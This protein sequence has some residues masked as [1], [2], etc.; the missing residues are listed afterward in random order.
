[1]KISDNQT[2]ILGAPGCGKT[3]SLLTL[4]DKCFQQGIKPHEIAFVSFS[5]RAANEALERACTKF[6][7][8]KVD[9]PYFRTLHSLAFHQLGLRANEV[10][11]PEDYNNLGKLLNAPFTIF[12][13]TDEI[14]NPADFGIEKKGDLMLFMESLARAKMAD[15]RDVYNV[16]HNYR[17]SW[18]EFERFA[19][20]YHEYRQHYSLMDFTDMLTQFVVSNKTVGVKVAFIDEAQ[21][22]SKLQW[23]VCQAAFNDCERVIIAGD[24]DQAIFKWAGADTNSFLELGGTKVVLSTSHRLPKAVHDV[25]QQVIRP[26]RTRYVKDFSPRPDLGFVKRVRDAQHVPLTHEG[27][28]LW[29]ARNTISLT[30]IER[31]LRRQNI[32]Y[33]TKNGSSIKALHVAAIQA[34]EALRKGEALHIRSIL[35]CYDYMK[36]TAAGKKKLIKDSKDETR[37]LTLDQLKQDYG[38]LIV[39]IWHDA[40]TGIPVEQREY[41]LAM[42]R[43]GIKLTDTI[44]HTIST[45]HGAKGAEADN[46]VLLSD[47][48]KNTFDAYSKNPDDERRVF[49]VGV[50]RAKQNLYLVDAQGIRGF[51]FPHIVTRERENEK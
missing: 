23:Q 10:M 49:Y 5:K 17:V 24:D 42:M 41:Y 11:R 22:L 32:P 38:V 46:V 31:L 13:K 28:W 27:S 40:L 30:N 8:K 47:M 45:I 21:D 7:F 51:K 36:T 48:G 37:V 15:L 1:M 25:A 39:D 16:H 3:T 29:L 6:N 14:E 19:K 26:I 2:V 4:V 33:I 12:K 34:W 50:T 18:L 44:K 35:L 43:R 20:T 9:L